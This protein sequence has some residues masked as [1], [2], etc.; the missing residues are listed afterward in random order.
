MKKL[1]HMRAH[2]AVMYAHDA[3]GR[4]LRVNQWDDSSLVPRLHL[5]LS[6]DG[7]ICRLRHDL[8]DEIAAALTRVAEQERGLPHELPLNEPRYREILAA[9]E[10][11]ERVRCGPAFVFPENFQFESTSLQIAAPDALLLQDALEP[12]R[13]DVPHRQPVF[14][15]L[16][17]GRAA[18][19][20][21]SARIGAAAH[22]AGVET[23]PAYRRQG[24][25]LN[26]VAGWAKAVQA[27]GCTP[28][29]STTWDN[30]ASQA[31][32]ARLGL[33]RIGTDYSI[34]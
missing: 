2:A 6:E 29:Y 12:W 11:I 25:A 1:E 19:I 13:P 34:V 28:Y 5:Y 4:M 22:A 32:A 17:D 8:P 7:A 16:T 23:D 24:H 30:T 20:C 33:I 31:I 9:H 27:M 21:C 26:A 15:S 18:A 14:I 10:P 3:R